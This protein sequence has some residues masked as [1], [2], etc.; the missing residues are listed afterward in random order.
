MT[1]QQHAELSATLNAVSG[2]VAIS[3]YECD[4]MDRL[5]PPPRWRKT[6]SEPRTNHATKGIRIEVL[7]TNFDLRET[8]GNSNASGNL[9]GDS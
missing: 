9:F 4:L 3:N 7:W 6:V 2:K 8:P 5:Y 1:N